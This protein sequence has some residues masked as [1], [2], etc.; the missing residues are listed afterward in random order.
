[1]RMT[2]SLCIIIVEL[3]NNIAFLPLLMITMLVAKSV[4]DLFNEG[5]YDTHVK[6]KFMPFLEQQPESMMR[7]LVAHD[8]MAKEVVE[9]GSVE[10]VGY[11]MEALQKTQHNGFPVVLR[12]QVYAENSPTQDAAT[13]HGTTFSGGILR[14]QLLVLLQQRH[15][16]S[17]PEAPQTEEEM[18]KMYGYAQ[19]DFSKVPTSTGMTVDDI[20]LT[21]DEEQMFVNL[22]PFVNPNPYV[23]QE[24]TSLGKV[25]A[26]FRGLGLRHLFV[27]KRVE[28]VIG[29]ITRKDLLP[30]F[31]EQRHHTKM[32]S[33]EERRE[34]SSSL[35]EKAQQQHEDAMDFQVPWSPRNSHSK[36]LEADETVPVTTV[37]L[38]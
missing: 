37:H 9:F 23:V 25:H 34:R 12:R 30:E 38:S 22:L 13:S 3:S 27:I 35:R 11:I 26:L 6:L 1:M 14:S 33:H 21:E 8:V 16:T 29:V 31:C 32:I 17:T 2:I 36:R 4:G 7:H 24:Q 15:F 20:H 5:I 28:K 18:E 19:M 10:R